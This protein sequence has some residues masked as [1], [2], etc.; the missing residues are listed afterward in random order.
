MFTEVS[1]TK[2]FPTYFKIRRA[3]QTKRIK[4]GVLFY[5]RGEKASAFFLFIFFFFFFAKVL[6]VYLR[7]DIA[8]VKL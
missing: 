3:A 8:K 5:G 1:E 7:S 2:R 4:I 6:L